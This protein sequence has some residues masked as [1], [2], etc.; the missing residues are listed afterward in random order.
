MGINRFE[1]C[2]L[3]GLGWKQHVAG[4]LCPVCSNRHEGRELR[5]ANE[6]LT[7]ELEEERIVNEGPLPPT[8]REELEAR[9]AFEVEANDMLKTEN[10]KLGLGLHKART[11][12]RIR[13]SEA[14][15]SINGWMECTTRAESRVAEIEGKLERAY[16][17]ASLIAKALELNEWQDPESGDE[18]CQNCLVFKG[19]DHEEGCWI[20]ETLALARAAA[21][22]KGGAP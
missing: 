21:A 1:T 2:D 16:D 17:A 4:E 18:L 14:Q 9:I 22:G 12:C 3:C 13:T 20:D 19:E 6:R 10:V 8:Q 5:T 7:R 11:I 15:A